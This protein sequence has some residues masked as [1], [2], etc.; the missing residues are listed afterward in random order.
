MGEIH[1]IQLK[2]EKTVLSFTKS[3]PNKIE[4]SVIKFE[5]VD[6]VAMSSTEVLTMKPSP[7]AH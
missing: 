7:A 4:G 2:N 6:A 5:I 1:W 3:P